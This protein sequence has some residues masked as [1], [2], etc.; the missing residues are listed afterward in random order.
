VTVKELDTSV[1]ASLT[2]QG[3]RDVYDQFMNTGKK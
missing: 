1:I 2:A 3:Y